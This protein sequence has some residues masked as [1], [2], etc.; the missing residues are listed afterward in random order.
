MKSPLK[1]AGKRSVRL[2]AVRPSG[3]KN[4]N[5]VWR[6]ICDCGKEKLVIAARFNA[7]FVKSCGCLGKEGKNAV[8]HGKSYTSEYRSWRAMIDRCTLESVEQYP[9]YG[10]RGITVCNR[11]KEGYGN[12]NSFGF[13]NFIKDLGMKPSPEHSLDRVNCNGNYEPSN[14]RWANR[15]QQSKNRRKFVCLTGYSDKEILDE[16]KRRKLVISR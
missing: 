14:C 13:L 2:V 7:G 9:N 10:G 16:L 11:W 6:C 8:R 5:I 4:R 3:R 12:K 1:L 15:S